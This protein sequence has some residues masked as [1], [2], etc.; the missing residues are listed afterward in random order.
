MFSLLLFPMYRLGSTNTNKIDLFLVSPG[1]DQEFVYS[2]VTRI[3]CQVFANELKENCTT[4]CIIRHIYYFGTIT[5]LCYQINHHHQHVSVQKAGGGNLFNIF[6]D[7]YHYDWG[8][9]KLHHIFDEHIIQTTYS[10]H[11]FYQEI[12]SAYPTANCGLLR[13]SSEWSW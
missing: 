7:C 1:D 4:L 5:L 9:S 2:P 3:W 10:H 13:E 11:I 6:M 8:E 12:T